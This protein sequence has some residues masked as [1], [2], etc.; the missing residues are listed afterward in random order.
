MLPIALPPVQQVIRQAKARVRGGNV[1]VAGS[2]QRA[3]TTPWIE[4]LSLSRR[5][6][7][8]TVG[9]LG[10]DRRQ[11][12]QYRSVPGGSNE[13]GIDM[14]RSAAITKKAKRKDGEKCHSGRN[15]R[16]GLRTSLLPILVF[17]PGSSENLV[18]RTTLVWRMQTCVHTISYSFSFVV[19]PEF[20]ETFHSRWSVPRRNDYLPKQRFFGCACLPQDASARRPVAPSRTNIYGCTPARRS[21]FWKRKFARRKSNS[22]AVFVRRRK[23]RSFALDDCSN[24]CSTLASFSRLPY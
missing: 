9:G 5:G 14:D 3:L 13:H 16:A 20:R 12:D 22:G 4:S 17:A 15:P 21:R 2:H 24:Q 1:H 6:R 7:H 11:S 18:T 19:V 8:A 10:S 23:L